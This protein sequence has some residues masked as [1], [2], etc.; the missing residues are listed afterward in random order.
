[1]SKATPVFGLIDC[2]SFYASCERVFRPDLAKVPIVVLSNNDGCVIARSY[3]A[4]PYV[5][6]GEP[7]FQIKNKLKQHGIVPFSSN[8]ALYGDMSE[9]VMTLIESLVPAVEVYSIDEAFADL[10]GINDLDGLGR[11]IRSQVLR[12][13]G[14]PVGVGIAHT[15]TLAKL[16]NYTAKRLQGQTGGVVN[17]CDPIKRDWVLRNT[18]VAEVWGVGRRMKLHLDGMG[19][20]TA[21]DLANADPWTLRKNFSVV[22]EKTARELAGTPCLE[23]DE[24]DPPKQEICCSR[25]FG[26]RLK[27]LP[28]IKEAVATYMMRASEKLRAQKSLCKKIRVSIRTG[29]F[30][31]DEAKYAN[32]VVIDLPYPTDD[33]RLLTTAAVNALDRVFR[34]GFSYSKA[35]VLLLNLC[36]PGEYTDDLFA[37][38]QPTEATRVMAVLDEINGR[39]GR[40]TL[41]AAS[42]PSNPDWGMRREM[43]SQSYTTRLDQLWTVNCR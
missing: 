11:K 41:R 28:P 36:Q 33:V 40:G 17:I 7:Y 27:E 21:M 16:A 25:M 42:V 22:I 9:R 4:K 39:W 18:D 2:N 43:M 32:G 20:K 8:Y 29:M 3:D 19:I 23:L 1:M 26:K 15:K 5:K 12:C 10:T 14:I 38:S 37:I 34:T 30:N 6:M 24:P 31:P 35:E 13:T